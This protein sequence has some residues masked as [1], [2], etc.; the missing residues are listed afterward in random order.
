MRESETLMADGKIGILVELENFAGWEPSEQWGDV[1]FFLKHDADIEKIAIVGDL[2]WRE[3]A[4]MFVFAGMRQAEVRFFPESELELARVWL[5]GR[6][7][8][9]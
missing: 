1:N 5:I 6:T 7:S 3:E 2:R 4:L 8:L 9:V